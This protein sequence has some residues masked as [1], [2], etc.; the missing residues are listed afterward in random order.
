MP[1]DIR[2]WQDISDRYH[3]GTLLL[4]NGASMAVA[5]SFGY[6][7]LL[8]H[9]RQNG[10]F[11]PDVASLFRHFETEDFELILRIV[12]HAAKVNR[13]L[14]IQDRR[15]RRA[16]LDVRD[17]L[18][19]AVRDVHPTYGD[20]RQHLAQ[21]CRF[22][23]SFDTVISLNYDLIVYWT[24]LFGNDTDDD[25]RFKDCFH[26]CVFQD[27]WQ[28]YRTPYRER[29]NT[30]VF[31]PHGNLALCREANDQ[32]GKIHAGAFGL[33]DGILNF[34]ESGHAI[35]LFVSEGS[36]SQ[37]V[38]SIRNSYYLSTVY[39]EVLKAE[40]QSLTLFG[41]G[42]GDHDRHILERMCNTGIQRVSVSVFG[43][44]E[45]YCNR[46]LQAIREDIGNVEVDFFDC[47]SP[48][49]WIQL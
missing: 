3:R 48:G 18:I 38:A 5:R 11:T 25:H 34:W 37:K 2:Q 7:S 16:Y 26:N 15:T 6:N 40:K 41:W 33:L 23:K 8:E 31:Y 4:G 19:R 9:A 32:E 17:A 10:L 44:D 36:K 12:W 1:V 43:N 13:Y 24:M 21:T 47:Q 30:L 27:N 22:L 35:P 49:C 42:I 20:V 39:R 46:A 28:N 14:A 29:I 45:A